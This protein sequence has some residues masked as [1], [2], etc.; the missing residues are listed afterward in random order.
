MVDHDARQASD[1]DQA[2]AEQLGKSLDDGGISI[3]LMGF[4][5]TIEDQISLSRRG[6]AFDLDCGGAAWAK[7]D[8][9]HLVGVFPFAITLQ[10]AAVDDR[11]A[12]NFGR[13]FVALRISYE[14]NV[15]LDEQPDDALEN[16]VGFYG[17]LHLWPYARA[18]VQSLSAKL[19]L[20]PLVLP[21]LR[22]GLL[23]NTLS[24]RRMSEQT[25]S[26]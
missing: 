20:P 4:S 25:E 12:T 13:I 2:K 6:L 21:V 3:S 8:A 24:I 18:E 17:F 10:A 11:P 9:I 19:G 14:F 5:A 23:P 22:P 1:F 15:P 7:V 26:D 16:F